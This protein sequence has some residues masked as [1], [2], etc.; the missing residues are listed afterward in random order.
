MKSPLANQQRPSSARGPIRGLCVRQ[1]RDSRAFLHARW[2][3]A[4]SPVWLFS[5]IRTDGKPSRTPCRRASRR[6]LT[7]LVPSWLGSGPVRLT[8]AATSNWT[9]SWGETRTRRCTRG[10][11]LTNRAWWSRRPSTR[12]TCTWCWAT[13]SCSWPS[14]R[15]AHWPRHWVSGACVTSNWWDKLQLNGCRCDDYMWINLISFLNCAP[16]KSGVIF[17]V[18]LKQS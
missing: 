8:P 15:R 2:V 16:M 7:S 4:E 18:I 17:M 5:P 14:T 1:D 11:D 10:S 6:R 13:S 12:R 9:R 3:S